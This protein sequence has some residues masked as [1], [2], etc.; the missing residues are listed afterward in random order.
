[1]NLIDHNTTPQFS[2]ISEKCS[3]CSKFQQISLRYT[4][5]TSKTLGTLYNGK[6]KEGKSTPSGE[7][8]AEELI[9]FCMKN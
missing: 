1:M 2:K 3:L 6:S 8:Y 9:T 4:A 5:F 7:F